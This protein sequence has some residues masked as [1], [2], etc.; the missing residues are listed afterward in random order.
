MINNSIYRGEN[1]KVIYRKDK[2]T[3]EVIA[4]FPDTYKLGTLVCYAHDGQHSTAELTYYRTTIKA[5]PLEYKELDKE[6]MELGYQ[7]EIKQKLIS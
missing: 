5:K 1:M 7:L 6:L 2:K 4:F 3:D